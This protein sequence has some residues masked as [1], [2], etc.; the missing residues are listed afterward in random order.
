[1]GA[2]CVILFAGAPV[3]KPL[4]RIDESVKV[5]WRLKDAGDF[6]CWETILLRVPR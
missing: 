5:V 3:V 6:A 1:M 2:T 4:Q